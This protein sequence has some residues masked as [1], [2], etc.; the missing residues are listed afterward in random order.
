MADEQTRTASAPPRPPATAMRGALAGRG[1]ARPAPTGTRIPPSLQAKMA[2][3]ANRG[4]HS[5]PAVP[6]AA[7][8]LAD[9]F[10]QAGV[11][12][13]SAPATP[14]GRGPL[15]PGRGGIS[16]RRP[17]PGLNLGQIDPSLRDG[18]PPGIGQGG[19]AAAAG[20]GAGNP[21]L[22]NDPPN[23]RPGATPFSNFSKIVYVRYAEFG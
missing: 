16:A 14:A 15:R 19:G 3:M 13:A 8:G 12:P 6:G 4:Q 17:G 11:A 21:N 18:P 2:A 7:P 9:A 5:S 20:L 23:K 1:L 10:I 22:R